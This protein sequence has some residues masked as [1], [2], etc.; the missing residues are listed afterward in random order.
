MVR[1]G[2]LRNPAIVPET[3]PLGVSIRKG[4]NSS[5]VARSQSGVRR[6]TPTRDESKLL[7]P[8]SR[9]PCPG[10]A[11]LWH[12]PARPQGPASGSM[13]SDRMGGAGGSRRAG[14]QPAAA[15]IMRL[16]SSPPSSPP[17]SNM[18]RPRAADCSVSGRWGVWLM[19][20]LNTSGRA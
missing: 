11:P 18:P 12:F 13:L 2:P 4:M 7:Q 16:G 17:A 19:P 1:I 5:R 20:K 15:V 6:G 8:L 10:M 14:A 9:S 3:C